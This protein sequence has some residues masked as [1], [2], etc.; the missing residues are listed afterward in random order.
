MED[1]E[2]A[3]TEVVGALSSLEKEL[4]GSP[5]VSDIAERTGFSQGATY[6]Y[7][8]EAVAAGMI[9]QRQGRFMTLAVARA[10]KEK[11]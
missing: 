7:L 5:S 8:R 4:G 1:R 10:F 2:K 6:I 3:I 9:A 11:K